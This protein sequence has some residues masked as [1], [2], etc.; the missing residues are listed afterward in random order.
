[1]MNNI[2]NISFINKLVAAALVSGVAITAFALISDGDISSDDIN[3]IFDFILIDNVLEHV[4]NPKK[5]LSE[6]SQL[7]RK[8]GKLLIIVPN[9]YDI[10][11]ISKKWSM[12]NFWIPHDH[13]SYFRKVDIEKMLLD[14]GYIYHS[15]FNYGNFVAKILKKIFYI[16]KYDILALSHIYT[17]K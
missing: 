10:R 1:M 16:A 4:L 9:R 5:F 12:K 3:E 7:L 11:R 17:K 15:R 2:S 13:L 6:I 14:L 8:D